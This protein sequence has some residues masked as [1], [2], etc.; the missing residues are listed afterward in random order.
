MSELRRKSVCV[1]QIFVVI[2]ILYTVAAL[3]ENGVCIFSESVSQES[4]FQVDLTKEVNY[5]LWVVDLNGPESISVK[6]NKGSY[7]VFEDTFTL[8]HPDSDYLPYHTKFA[9]KENGTYQVHVKPLGSGTVRLA[10][11]KSR[12]PKF[13]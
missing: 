6:I 2:F 8:M 9:V 1:I 10:V 3:L 7:V 13:L 4:D 12:I 11:M 5:N